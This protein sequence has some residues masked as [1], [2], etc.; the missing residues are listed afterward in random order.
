[1]PIFTVVNYPRGYE[2]EEG[3]YYVFGRSGNCGDSGMEGGEGRAL[4]PGERNNS[5]LEI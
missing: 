1:M 4:S 5:G 2:K 3:L